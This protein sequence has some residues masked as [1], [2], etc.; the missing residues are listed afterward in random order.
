MIQNIDIKT[1]HTCKTYNNERSNK[2]QSISS[3]N[4]I[5]DQFSFIEFFQLSSHRFVWANWNPLN[6]WWIFE[7]QRGHCDSYQN[8]FRSNKSNWSRS[9][10][11]NPQFCLKTK[12][13]NKVEMEIPNSTQILKIIIIIIMIMTR[14]DNSPQ[15]H[16]N[17]LAVL[18][19]LSRL[20]ATLKLEI[21]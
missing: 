1:K 19:V 6:T 10:S 5:F 15:K 17:Q 21:N 12:L 14:H 8:P 7:E 16:T 20:H 2:V 13:Y 4:I 18:E 11:H 3:H 9:I